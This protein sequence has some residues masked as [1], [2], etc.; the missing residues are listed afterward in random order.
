MNDI[1]T[2]L[3]DLRE[4]A[5]PRLTDRVMRAIEAADDYVEIP[6][7]RGALYVAFNDEGISCVDAAGGRSGRLPLP[8]EGSRRRSRPVTAGRSAT[9][10]AA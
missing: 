9:T 7:P 2:A 6:G 4:E 1:E 8:R 5:P 10:F 3:G